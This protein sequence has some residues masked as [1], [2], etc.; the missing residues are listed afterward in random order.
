MDPYAVLGVDRKASMD[1]IKRAYREQAAKYHPDKYA[2]HELEDLAQ[3]KMKQINQAYDTIV[4]EREG[5][6]GSSSRGRYGG[7]AGAWGAPGSGSAAYAPVRELINQGRLDEAESMLA[8]FS[9]DAEWYFL[10]GAIAYRR[11]WFDE[12]QA[13]WRNAVTMDPSNPEYQQAFQYARREP[14]YGGRSS[15][16]YGNPERD[17]CQCCTALMCADCLCDCCH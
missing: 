1:E 11:G 7:N 15:Y 16:S 12:A 9:H 10:T 8:G 4:R 17:L 3:E 2:G 14:T 6:G 5:G 13:N